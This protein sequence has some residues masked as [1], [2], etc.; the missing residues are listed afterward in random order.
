VSD[1]ALK[2]PAELAGRLALRDSRR[3]LLVDAPPSLEELLSREAPSGSSIAS[4]PADAIRS[5]KQSFDAI[6]AW[7]EDRVGSRAFF[8]TLLKRLDLSATLWI[9]TAMKKVTGPQTPAAR[10]LELSD[11]VKAFSGAGFRHDREVRV[12]AWHVAYRFVRRKT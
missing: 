11:L 3:L 6:L 10:R 12:S 5:V 2:N 9:V 4:I 8:E 7:R 1:I